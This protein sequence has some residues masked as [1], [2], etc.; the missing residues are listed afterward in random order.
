MR[1][2]KEKLKAVITAGATILT[3]SAC[4]TQ[5]TPNEKNDSQIVTEETTSE[6]ERT[7]TTNI[8]T[9]TTSTKTTSTNETVTTATTKSNSTETTKAVQTTKNNSTDTTQKNNT[10]QTTN[11]KETTEETQEETKIT[12]EKEN[13]TQTTKQV[14]TPKQTEPQTEA[15]TEAPTEPEIEIRDYSKYDLLDSNP[16]VAA[17]AFEQLSNELCEELYNGY[18]VEREYGSSNGYLESRV[19]LAALNHD[20]GIS[21]EALASDEALGTYS[22]EEL[23]MYSHTIGFGEL[24]YITDSR[25]DFTKYVLNEDLANFINETNDAWVDAYTSGDR[26]YFYDMISSYCSENNF[27]DV[28]AIDDY[29]KFYYVVASAYSFLD[30]SVEEESVEIAEQLY[31]DNIVAPIYDSYSPYRGHSYS[32]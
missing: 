16:E 11:N 28:N 31:N 30:G 8:H 17:R 3:L 27:D 12:V 14:E 2:N 23:L 15:P 22:Y 18:A 25:V 20:Q 5:D 26:E 21:V 1:I 29:T 6:K 13:Q 24:E 32:R 9:T 10:T 7:E 19:I 4:G